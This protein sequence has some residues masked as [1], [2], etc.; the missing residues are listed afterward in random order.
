MQGYHWVFHHQQKV[1][2]VP[3]NGKISWLDVI[4]VHAAPRHPEC[5]SFGQGFSF[6]STY[7]SG[8]LLWDGNLPVWPQINAHMVLNTPAVTS[9]W[10]KGGGHMTWISATLGLQEKWLWKVFLSTDIS[11]VF[12]LEFEKRKMQ[13]F[14][15]INPLGCCKSQKIP[16]G[17]GVS[18]PTVS[19]QQERVFKVQF[20]FKTRKKILLS[21]AAMRLRCRKGGDRGVQ[22]WP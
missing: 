1:V 5:H 16:F 22:L 7:S 6:Y 10:T 21:V 20:M 14:F 2:P 8:S 11:S 9:S 12:S 18:C 4:P 17:V 13:L 3:T 19:C 15:L